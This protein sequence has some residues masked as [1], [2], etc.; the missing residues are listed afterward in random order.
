ML[1]P[2]AVAH[3]DAI[4]L[5]LRRT[6]NRESMRATQRLHEPL[7]VNGKAI[8]LFLSGH[9]MAPY[10]ARFMPVFVKGDVFGVLCGRIQFERDDYDG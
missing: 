10:Y 8:A 3:W 6:L 2:R 4:S 5:R 7:H 9:R 1:D